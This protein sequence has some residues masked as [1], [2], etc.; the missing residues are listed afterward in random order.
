[1]KLRALLLCTLL[2]WQATAAA[3]DIIGARPLGMAGSYRGIASSNDAIFFNPAGMSL[4]RRY[5]LELQYLL[6][7]DY[8]AKGA[9]DQHA[10]QVSVVDNQIQYFAT[11]LAYT[12]VERGDDKSGNRYDMAFSVPLTEGLLIGTDIKYLDFEREG[13]ADVNAVSVDVGMLLHTSFGLNIGV[14]GYNLTNTADYLEHPI[15]MGLGVMYSPF[16]TLELSFDWTVNFQKLADIDDPTGE[17]GT[18][19]AFSF[20]AE[21]LLFGQITLRAGYRI[22]RSQPTGN[23]QYWAVGAG[24][25]SP[26]FAF[27][28]GYRGAV[29]HS[30]W[31][32]HCGFG[33]SLF[34]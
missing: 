6:V 25:I 17:K 20:G 4:F 14:V 31:G 29:G 23:E 12:R 30:D 22:D 9:A 33:M 8:A 10:V 34:L 13:R 24:Y 18:G 11:G 2:G 3:G 26:T 15:S 5:A 1:M 27:D 7:P 21:Y 32:N 19:H 28:F 16:R